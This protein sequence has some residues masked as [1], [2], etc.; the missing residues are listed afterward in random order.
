MSQDQPFIWKSCLGGPIVWWGRIS[1]ISKV[2]LTVL[3]RLMESQIWHLPASSVALWREGS[4]N[5]QWP[6][7]TS[8]SGRKLSPSSCLDAR[9][10]RFS[11][12]APGAFQAATLVLELR[13]S[14][15]E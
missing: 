15:S 11:L 1:R 12:C 6:L 2:G 10:F 8:L 7:P 3:A 4:E 5:R 13:G 9:H 14:K